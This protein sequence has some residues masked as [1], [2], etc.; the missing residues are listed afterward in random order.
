MSIG[1]KFIGI[2]LLFNNSVPESHKFIF[3]VESI[4]LSNVQHINLY[5]DNG[6]ES[7][8]YNAFNFKEYSS[9]L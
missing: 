9:E 7:V 3:L 1:I 8:L 2:K 4:C 5:S 6:L